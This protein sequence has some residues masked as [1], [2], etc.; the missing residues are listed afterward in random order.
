[1]PK[2]I[3]DPDV[4]KA[5][6]ETILANGYAGATTK[7]IAE[8]AGINEATLFRR[9]GS[10]AELI[11]AAV[12]HGVPA[13]EG[14]IPTYTGDLTADLTAIVQAYQASSDIHAR[15]FPLIM[16]E[17]SRYPELRQ[18][19]A[20]PMRFMQTVGQILVQYQT[21]GRLLQEDP[22]RAVQGLLGPVIVCGMV[23]QANPDIPMPDFDLP[24]HIRTYIKGRTP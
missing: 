9:Y 7:M 24:F 8:A 4:Y 18:T 10:K 13:G 23:S 21:D 11:A 20:G 12:G 14:Q 15:L 19:M 16:S 22:I 2:Q 6:L 5:A 1:M 3:H 17:M